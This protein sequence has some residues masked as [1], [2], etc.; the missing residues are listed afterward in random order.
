V[1]VGNSLRC[2][3]KAQVQ[4]PGLL[5]IDEEQHFLALVTRAPEGDAHGIFHVLTLTATP[6]SRG[7]CSLADGVRDL[8]IIGT[9]PSTRLAIRTYVSEFD[10]VNLTRSASLRGAF[11][12]AGNSFYVFA[13]RLPIFQ[14]SRA[15]LKEATA[16]AFTYL[17]R[18]GQMAAG[19]L[20][21]RIERVLTT[22]NMTHSC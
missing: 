21:D 14:R 8:S 16:R 13:A 3:R 4:E 12:A 1:V 22:A 19:E 7:P 15:F 5:I 2:W 6:I 10:A 18:H 17:C 11:I 9:R 20:D